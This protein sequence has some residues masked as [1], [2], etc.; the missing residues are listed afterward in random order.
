MSADAYDCAGLVKENGDYA[1]HLSEQVQK[2][3][4]SMVK[5]G[6]VLVPFRIWVTKDDAERSMRCVVVVLKELIHWIL[7]LRP[8]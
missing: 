5:G 7:G 3:L 6:I 2:Q 4:D 8:T 1:A